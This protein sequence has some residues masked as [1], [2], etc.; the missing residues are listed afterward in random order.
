MPFEQNEASKLLSQWQEMKDIRQ[1]IWDT[2]FQQCK[3][4]VWPNSE[5][6]TVTRQPGTYLVELCYDSTAPEANEQFAN[7][8]HA[9][10]ANPFEQWFGIELQDEVQ[11]NKDRDVKGWLQKVT[12]LISNC[13]TNP[14]AN[15]K[16]SLHEYFLGTGCLGTA[17]VCQE[18]DDSI[19]STCYSSVNLSNFWISE[20]DYGRIFRVFRR[21]QWTKRQAIE[22]FGEDNL[23][24][25][26]M[27]KNVKMDIDKWD[28]IHCVQPRKN[29]NPNGKGWKDMPYESKWL[30]VGGALF[31]GGGGQPASP[32]E[33]FIC[34]EGGYSSL[35]YHVGRWS[36]ISGQEYGRSPAMTALPDI[37]ILNQMTK[38]TL[39][40]GQKVV[41][42][43]ILAPHDSFM[44]Q[45]DQTPGAVNY[46]DSSLGMDKDAIRPL[47]TGA[48]P[49]AGEEMM[50]PKK[51]TVNKI[52]YTN[53]GNIPFKKERQSVPE[54][55]QQ[56]DAILRNIAPL[57]GRQEAELLGP[58]IQRTFE[59]LQRH[60]KIPPHPSKIQGKKLK[61]VYQSRAAQAIKAGKLGAIKS[62]I[63][64]TIVPMIQ[65]AP[66]SKDYLNTDAVLMES[67]VLSNVTMD[68]F[69]TPEQVA[70]IRQDR[71]KQ[72]QQQQQ[73]Q[74][75]ES[76]SQSLKNV[77]QAGQ[78][79]PDLVGAP[80]GAGS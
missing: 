63:N 30:F 79:L 43:P 8:M 58:M 25:K 36:K 29:Y 35:P 64:E 55:Q 70:A 53:L 41:D 72:Q 17:S 10:V 16:Q 13:Y 37:R 20:D 80:T 9:A 76:A 6:F 11:L 38:V 48:N 44:S 60:G 28:F 49:Q 15:H 61:I 46:Y 39:R 14:K 74:A 71:A 7:G 45:L 1:R 68:I 24:P 19:D 59:L 27:D 54:I 34:W 66:E 75:A 12:D 65:L 22:R 40:A 67:A 69:R 26:L 56:Q 50:Q 52:F 51:D 42:P 2:L 77:G 57:V 4:V 73:L 47:V 32:S 33:P 62:F 31:G 3:D 18:W 5:D 78:A 21:V 23:P